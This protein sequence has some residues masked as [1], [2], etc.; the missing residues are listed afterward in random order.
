[1]WS[2][3]ASYSLPHG[4]DG[5]LELQGNL[6]WLTQSRAEKLRKGQRAETGYLPL[7]DWDIHAPGTRTQAGP[8]ELESASCS[9]SDL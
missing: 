1:M 5:Q 4:K 7:Q 2:S 9:G 3:G 6:P 8:K